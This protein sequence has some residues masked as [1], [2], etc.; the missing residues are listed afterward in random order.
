MTDGIKRRD[1]LKVVGVTGVSTAR[2]SAWTKL[3]QD[4]SWRNSAL[5][6]T[7][8]TSSSCHS[9]KLASTR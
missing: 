5:A 2:P 8:S 6:G 1:F 4:P 7:C 9:T 3:A